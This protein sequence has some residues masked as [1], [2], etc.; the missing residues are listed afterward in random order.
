MKFK[1]FTQEAYDDIQSYMGGEEQW[2]EIN[3]TYGVVETKG[4][5]QYDYESQLRNAAT[6]YQR[7]NE[8]ASNSVRRMFDNVN[9]VD[10]LYAARFRD[11]YMDLERFSTAIKDLAALINVRSVENIYTMDCQTMKTKAGN[12]QAKVDSK[13]TEYYK[14]RFYSVDSNGKT[15]MNWDEINYEMRKEFVPDA[16]LQAL[17][18]VFPKLSTDDEEETIANIENMLRA[19]YGNAKDDEWIDNADLEDPKYYS[20]SVTNTFKR[21]V[22]IYKTSMDIIDYYSEKC[23]YRNDEIS[24]EAL[25]EMKEQYRVSSLFKAMVDSYP[26]IGVAYNGKN[27]GFTIHSDKEKNVTVSVCLKELP[28]DVSICKITDSNDRE[29]LDKYYN[30]KVTNGTINEKVGKE[31]E[32]VNQIDAYG[33]VDNQIVSHVLPHGMIEN[34]KQNLENQKEE[35]KTECRVFFDVTSD[36]LIGMIIDEAI[37]LSAVIIKETVGDKI[38]KANAAINYLNDLNAAYDENNENV[39]NN[40]EIDEAKDRLTETD[41]TCQDMIEDANYFGMDMEI[42]RI[43]DTYICENITT[44]VEKVTKMVDAY[45]AQA[46][47]KKQV[48]IKDLE[49][50]ARGAG[51]KNQREDDES[52]K[53]LCRRVSNYIDYVIEN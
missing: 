5:F 31:N 32:K 38:N 8:E 47:P 9:G 3:K 41:F 14:E 40:A 44:D 17:V 28:F 39:Q 6:E 45:N 25:E 13:I 33:M 35:E 1:D 34:T 42:T 4:I 29:I 43:G 7:Q 19:G 36:T 37:G 2:E 10:D 46:E 52:Y 11:E 18:S 48:S 50:Y 21:A 27:D 23:A 26:T 53:D 16:E 12:I 49:K 15:V 20:V 24:D 30:V 22:D 51:N